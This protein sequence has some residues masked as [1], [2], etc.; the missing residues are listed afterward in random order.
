V[1]ANVNACLRGTSI[2]PREC[3]RTKEALWIA[4]QSSQCYRRVPHGSHDISNAANNSW[5]MLL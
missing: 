2:M 5:H 3:G 1:A 4:E